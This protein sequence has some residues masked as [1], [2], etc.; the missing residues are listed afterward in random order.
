VINRPTDAGRLVVLYG[1]LKLPRPA[2]DPDVPP[3][4]PK[5]PPIIPPTDS[6]AENDPAVTPVSDVLGAFVNFGGTVLPIVRVK[7]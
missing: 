6:P 2:C 7:V 1:R 5:P 3:V 4:L